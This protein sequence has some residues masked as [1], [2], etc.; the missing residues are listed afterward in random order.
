MVAVAFA[1]VKRKLTCRSISISC[2]LPPM[3]HVDGG[4]ATGGPI[5][6]GRLES[7]VDEGLNG[8]EI[9]SKCGMLFP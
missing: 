6:A 4:K 3:F 1:T 5:S 9:G 8:P 7:D 2:S